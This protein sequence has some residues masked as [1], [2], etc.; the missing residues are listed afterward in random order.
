MVESIQQ[1]WG[2]PEIFIYF[3]LTR[4]AHAGPQTT[5]CGAGCPEVGRRENRTLRNP[6]LH[7]RVRRGGCKGIE[8]GKRSPREPGV[9]EV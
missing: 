3:K 4:E 9:T 5:N 1:V 8:T 7:G 2:E 6:D